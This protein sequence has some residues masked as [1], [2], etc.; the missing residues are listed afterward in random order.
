MPGKATFT[1]ICIAFITNTV[2]LLDNCPKHLLLVLTIGLGSHVRYS[3]NKLS[4]NSAEALNGKGCVFALAFVFS[5]CSALLSPLAKR[6]KRMK[7][8]G[9]NSDQL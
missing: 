3:P 2:S 8:T 6:N 5:F 4:V 9:T 1:I 7:R